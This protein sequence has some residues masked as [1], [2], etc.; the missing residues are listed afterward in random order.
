M[1]FGYP[2]IGIPV[3]GNTF[4]FTKVQDKDLITFDEEVN[5]L[6]QPFNVGWPTI[7][8]TDCELTRIGGDYDGGYIICKNYLAQA[9]AILNLGINDVDDFGC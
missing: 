4:N 7:Q 9:E 5:R 1:T 6:L 8:D 3:P 2:T